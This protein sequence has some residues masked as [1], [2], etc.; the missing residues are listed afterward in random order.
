MKERYLYKLCDLHLSVKSYTEAAFTLLLHAELLKWSDEAL[1][2]ANTIIIA[3][4]YPD[5]KT[6]R[7]LKERLYLEA[8]EY[9]DKGNMW[10]YGIRYRPPVA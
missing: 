1:S 3:N 5:V 6:Q 4:R 7:E 10:E 2:S 8:I 9:F